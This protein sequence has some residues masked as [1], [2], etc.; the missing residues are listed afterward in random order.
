MVQGGGVGFVVVVLG[1]RLA[2]VRG[3]FRLLLFFNPA[4]LVKIEKLEL[5]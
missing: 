4:D 1:Y 3:L 2:L 5:F